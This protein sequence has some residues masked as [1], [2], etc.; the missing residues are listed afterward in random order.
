MP[1]SFYRK[2]G[3]FFMVSWQ[4][5]FQQEIDSA[6]RARQA[7]NEGRA[8]VCAR[9]AAGIV[10]DVYLQM[11][12]NPAPTH[13]VYDRLRQLHLMDELSPKTKE[14]VSHFLERVNEDHRLPIEADLIQ[15]AVWLKEHLLSGKRILGG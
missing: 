6:V 14:M 12:G 8:R 5:H 2:V 9:R 3:V 11:H 7:D 10:A 15:E 1:P 13:S 4:N